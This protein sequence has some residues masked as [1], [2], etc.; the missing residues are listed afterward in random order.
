[1]GVRPSVAGRHPKAEEQ[2]RIGGDEHRRSGI[3]ENSDLKGRGAGYARRPP[4][5]GAL[6]F[7][8]IAD[9]LIPDRSGWRLWAQS[10]DGFGRSF[11]LRFP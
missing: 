6:L 8:L 4:G 1:M 10:V 3:R 5:G 2:Q 11:L 9:E 7:A